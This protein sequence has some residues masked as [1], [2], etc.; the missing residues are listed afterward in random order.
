LEFL[1]DLYS[2]DTIVKDLYFEEKQAESFVNLLDIYLRRLNIQLF[3]E[4]DNINRN[5]QE[6]E[7]NE[8]NKKE[9]NDDEYDD[10]GEGEEKSNEN[11]DGR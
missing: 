5:T 7:G 3:E 2:E 11:V 1:K 8:I 9:G 10:E 4:E 6:D